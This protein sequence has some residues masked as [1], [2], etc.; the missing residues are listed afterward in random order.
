M[1]GQQHTRCAA[2]VVLSENMQWLIIDNI[3]KFSV[4]SAYII[5]RNKGKEKSDHVILQLGD[6]HCPTSIRFA[7]DAVIIQYKTLQS[8]FYKKSFTK[9]QQNSSSAQY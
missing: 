7:N 9:A 3:L 6:K 5:M 8:N 2:F 1:I 4:C